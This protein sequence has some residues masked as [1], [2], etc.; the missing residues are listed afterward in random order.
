MLKMQRRLDFKYV[1]SLKSSISSF[2]KFLWSLIK[3]IDQAFRCSRTSHQ[4][5]KYLS[6]YQV[7]VLNVPLHSLY[8]KCQKLSWN[9]SHT[10]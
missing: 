10:N 6:K 9:Q 7:V 2:I 8:H 1:I 5:S 3:G 4:T